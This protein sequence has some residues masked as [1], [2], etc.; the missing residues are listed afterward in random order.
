VQELLAK[1]I[2]AE[3]DLEAVV[4]VV[5]A[6]LVVLELAAQVVLVYIQQS[7][8]QML[9]MLAVEVEVFIMLPRQPAG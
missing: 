3:Q 4:A 2:T 1:E 9:R 6:V 7:A 8:E 5:L